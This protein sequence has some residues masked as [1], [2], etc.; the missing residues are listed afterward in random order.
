MAS[1]TK[2]QLKDQIETWKSLSKKYDVRL[3]NGKYLPS[4]FYHVLLG[5]S[6][7]T[8]KKIISGEREIPKYTV[9]LVSALNE[10]SEKAF[11]KK[12][13]SH[14]PEYTKLHLKA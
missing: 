14:I 13:R 3:S 11:I 9:E 10:L 7:S 12:L 4:K 6:Y 8:L 5:V 1:L 2:E